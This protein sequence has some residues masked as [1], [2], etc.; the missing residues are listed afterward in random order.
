MDIAFTL[1]PWHWLILVFLFLGAEALGA[2]GFLLGSAIAAAVVSLWLWLVPEMGW[3][4]QLLIFGIGSLLFT[5]AYWKLFRNVNNKND[6]PELNNRALQLVGRTI[7][8]EHDLPAGQSRLQIGDTLWKVES[9][10]NISQGCKVSVTGHR[11]MV[12][13]VREQV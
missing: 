6:S 1:Q 8:L 5:L 7:T 11:G 3:P 2:G 4:V 9:D 10:R 12:L 13:L